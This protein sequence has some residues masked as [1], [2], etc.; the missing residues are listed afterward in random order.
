[1]LENFQYFLPFQN[2]REEL[3][4]VKCSLADANHKLTQL[5]TFKST[6]ARML[7]IRENPDCDVL[8]KLQTVVNA[9]HEF[10]LLSK[11]YDTS[12]MPD[13][14]CSP[15]CPTDRFIDDQLPPQTSSS[16]AQCRPLSSG[17]PSHRRY[18][19]SGF[20]H[21]DDDFEFSKKF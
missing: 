12:P 18:I 5:H 2:L 8:Q 11:R 21:F 15:N 3:N 9:H 17:S 16:S 7:H 14:N 19:D 10:T 4:R 13:P 1:M 20:D 6:V